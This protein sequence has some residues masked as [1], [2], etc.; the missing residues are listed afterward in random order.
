M[1]TQRPTQA[2]FDTATMEAWLQQLQT[3]ADT[4]YT[5]AGEAAY[6]HPRILTFNTASQRNE[7]IG[8]QADAASRD[9]LAQPGRASRQ[10]RN[11]VW[12]GIFDTWA[13]TYVGLPTPTV[14]AAPTNPATRRQTNQWDLVSWHQFA[15]AAVQREGQTGRALF[16]YD[17][18]VDITAQG[19]SLAS[20]ANQRMRNLAFY[21][22]RDWGVREV[23]IGNGGG[24]QGGQDQCVNNSTAWVE[25]I[26]GQQARKVNTANLAQDGR[27]PNFRAVTFSGARG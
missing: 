18:D 9:Y 4:L 13:S 24:N 25:Q 12:V 27:F 1:A 23:F 8:Y 26:A 5:T 10:G 14:A 22:R 16:I 20:S 21:A 11:T 6:V 2:D 19:F 7:W 15:W 17:Q 3:H